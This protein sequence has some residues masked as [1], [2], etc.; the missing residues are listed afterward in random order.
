MRNRICTSALL[1]TV[2][3]TAAR[4]QGTLPAQFSHWTS[5]GPSVRIGAAAV[6]QLS[7]SDAAILRE[8]GLLDAERRNYERE[9]RS[10]SVTLYRLR[11]TSGAYAAF[12]A[13][14]TA[15]M[16]GADLALFSAMGKTRALLV[17]GQHLLDA[18]G[19][20]PVSR[21]EFRD[22]V[23]PL[24]PSAD[25]T[26]YPPILSYLPTNGRV[27]NSEKYLLGPA[28]LQAAL[29]LKLFAFLP[30]GDWL[31]F[32]AGAEAMVARYCNGGREFHVL[33]AEYP[34]PQAASK[35]FKQIELQTSSAPS[36]PP[37]LIARRKGS[38]LS[39]VLNP[40]SADAA[41]TL[42]DQVLY[43]T[44]ITWNEPSHKFKEPSFNVMVVEAFVGTGVILM[45]AIIAGLGFGGLRILTKYLLPGK[46][47]D[48]EERV[49]IL[50]LGI[51]SKPIEAKDFY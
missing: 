24:Q 37:Q 21:A 48:R 22:L 3:A 51:S 41:N 23:S 39:M 15:D 25:S 29:A 20:E 31:G 5:S 9:G 16:V 19:R 18:T 10:L 45:F 7:G 40:T 36:S 43:Q 27:P 26:P 6:S 30:K 1:L 44:Q 35:Q 11:D 47:F 17:I 34:T 4:G 49:E 33:L 50:Q 14:R 12:T 13:L 28:G 42:L 2:A 46:V 8:D 32:G 38:L